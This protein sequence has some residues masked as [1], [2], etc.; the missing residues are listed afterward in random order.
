MEQYRDRTRK[1]IK[2][3]LE[4]NNGELFC[5][6]LLGCGF[7]GNTVPDDIPNHKGMME[8]PTSDASNPGIV[9]GSS[10]AGRKPIYIVRYQGFLSINLWSL[11]QY[12]AKSKEMWG[13]PCPIFIRAISMS[14]GI[15]P[16][17]S[18]YH[19][20][21]AIRYPGL[22]IY[23]PLTPNEFEEAW[24]DFISGDDP[25]ICSE[26]RLSFPIDYEISNKTLYDNNPDIFLL[27]IGDARLECIKA[28]KKLVELEYKTEIGHITKLKP[29][30]IPENI[31]KCIN[32]KDTAIIIVDGDYQM[33]GI[34]EH[35]AYKLIIENGFKKVYPLGI[36][37]KT[38]GFASYCDNVTPTS[39]IILKFI[40]KNFLK[41]EKLNV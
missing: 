5:Q 6:A 21:S 15:G 7:V 27:G 36:K 38:A 25:V 33:C 1:I 22:K 24:E 13:I 23:A 16:V 26:S 14:G 28:Q 35:I 9:I 18:N 32:Q 17:A 20:S 41:K 31:L 30:C 11:A 10:L 4:K 29:L 39:E 12:A 3:H 2:N 37:D 8:L 40:K 19:H 34:S